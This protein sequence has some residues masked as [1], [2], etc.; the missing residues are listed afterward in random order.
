VQRSSNDISNQ[1]C[2]VF[3]FVSFVR[4]IYAPNE[5]KSFLSIYGEWSGLMEAKWNDGSRSQPEVFVDVNS[6]PI[7]KKKVRPIVEQTEHESRRIWRD[8]TAGLK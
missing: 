5:K 4:Q 7:Y 2:L 8:V 1:F 3:C 6:I